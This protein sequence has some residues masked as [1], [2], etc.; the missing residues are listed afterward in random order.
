[1][2]TLPVRPSRVGRGLANIPAFSP[3]SSGLLGVGACA[4]PETRTACPP[5]DAPVPS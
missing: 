3:I 5:P 2:Y 1:M 4:R